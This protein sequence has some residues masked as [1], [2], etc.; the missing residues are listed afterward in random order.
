M[1]ILKDIKLDHWR[2][3]FVSFGEKL[4]ICIHSERHFYSEMRNNIAFGA[5]L[6]VA[7]DGKTARKLPIHSYI[8]YGNTF[9]GTADIAPNGSA[10][11]SLHSSG[12]SVLHIVVSFNDQPITF[13]A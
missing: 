1:E 3:Y 13:D 2:N 11:M 12:I 6:A 9:H 8:H 7:G 4:R 5:Q 10:V